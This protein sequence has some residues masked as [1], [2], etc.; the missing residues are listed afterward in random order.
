MKK[1]YYINNLG[2]QKIAEVPKLKLIPVEFNWNEAVSNWWRGT[3]TI[4]TLPYDAS[5]KYI[6]DGFSDTNVSVE[7]IDYSDKKISFYVKSNDKVPVLV[8]A[9]YS[10]EWKAYDDGEATQI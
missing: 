5:L 8:K 7:V 2:I 9:T 4:T 3:G 1:Y 10:S 6:D